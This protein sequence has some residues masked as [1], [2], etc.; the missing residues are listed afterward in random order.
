MI[1]VPQEHLDL[2]THQKAF[3]GGVFDIDVVNLDL[4]QFLGLRLDTRKGRLHIA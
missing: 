2:A 4:L 1:H 3:K